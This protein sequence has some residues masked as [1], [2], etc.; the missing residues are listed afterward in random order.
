M[1]AEWEL[2]LR[3]TQLAWSLASSR[4]AHMM[5]DAI[6]DAVSRYLQPEKAEVRGRGFL[7]A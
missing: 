5:R 6:T 1:S 7:P 2:H 4:D 3:S